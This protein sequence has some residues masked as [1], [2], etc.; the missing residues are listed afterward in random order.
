MLSNGSPD[1]I[2]KFAGMWDVLQRH[3]AI[4]KIGTMPGI[5][6]TVKI[7]DKFDLDVV[8]AYNSTFFISRIKAQPPVVSKLTE[9][10]KELTVS[11][12]DFKKVLAA[13]V[14]ALD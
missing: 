13:Q 10:R 8:S 1:H 14:M 11:A 3:P 5:F 7:F 9:Q 2:D 12:P 4:D 6:L